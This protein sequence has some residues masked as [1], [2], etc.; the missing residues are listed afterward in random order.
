MPS[1]FLG[2]LVLKSSG[3]GAAL[4]AHVK[5]ALG[6]ALLVVAA[7]L[8]IRPLLTRGR[9]AGDSMEP[10]VVKKLQTDLPLTLFKVGNRIPAQKA[11]LSDSTVKADANVAAFAAS[12]QDGVPMPNIAAMAVVWGPAGGVLDLL[13]QNKITPAAAGDKVVKDIKDGIAQQK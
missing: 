1:A 12:A 10:L 3:Q 7:G 13:A 5:L 2:V 4:Q 9:K 11:M 6:L 8:I